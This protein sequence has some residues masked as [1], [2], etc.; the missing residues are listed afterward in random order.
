M[1][2]GSRTILDI[3]RRNRSVKEPD[4]AIGLGDA[5]VRA[6]LFEEVAEPNECSPL[7]FEPN[8]MGP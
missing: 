5:L 3:V 6:T 1:I 8:G 2:T 7:T 4:T